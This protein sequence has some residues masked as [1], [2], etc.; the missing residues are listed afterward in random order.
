MSKKICIETNFDESKLSYSDNKFLYNK[1]AFLLNTSRLVVKSIDD[2]NISLFLSDGLLDILI[3]AENILTSKKI[4]Y[5][6]IIRR[7]KDGDTFITLSYSSL[8]I[9]DKTKHEI[10]KRGLAGLIK[11]GSV[12]CCL[13]DLSNVVVVS[14]TTVHDP[15][16]LVVRLTKNI[17]KCNVRDLEEDSSDDS[18]YYSSESE[19]EAEPVK[20]LSE[21]LKE[22]EKVD[23]EEEEEITTW[24]EL[25]RVV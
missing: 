5:F 24:D 16:L 4:K 9:Y 10:K 22:K 3:Q 14:G 21:L 1:N 15:R 20:P 23:E 12:I 6:P 19:P 17:T 18:E 7:T 25:L 11:S 2:T 13:F 8:K